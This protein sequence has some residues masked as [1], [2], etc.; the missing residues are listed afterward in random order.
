MNGEKEICVALA[1]EYV[2]HDTLDDERQGQKKRV[3]E[4]KKILTDARIV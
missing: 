1:E 2:P 4:G 3:R